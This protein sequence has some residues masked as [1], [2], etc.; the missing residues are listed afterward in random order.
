MEN[1]NK[2]EVVEGLSGAG[3][4]LAVV[5]DYFAQ[6][7]NVEYVPFE[8]LVPSPGN[9]VIVN[10]QT[11]NEH[12]KLLGFFVFDQNG[13]I[14]EYQSELTLK[15]DN[16]DI[17]NNIHAAIIEKTSNLSISDTAFK[18]NPPVSIA[19]SAVKIT[20]QDGGVIPGAN[21]KVYLYLICQKRS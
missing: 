3:K 21:R 17:F 14:V 19:N 18:M 9:R 8:I 16:I 6:F 13:K 2:T 4:G 5:K 11:K 10:S 12:H 20:Y 7:P 1:I 15:I